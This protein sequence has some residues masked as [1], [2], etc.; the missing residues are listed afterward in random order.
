V[1]TV[2][3]IQQHFIE[4]LNHAIRRPGMFGPGEIGLDHT[5][6]DVV[7]VTETGDRQ[8]WRAALAAR[9]AW[10]SIGVEGRLMLLMPETE[11][12]AAASVYADYAH[13]HEWLALD[14]VLTSDEYGELRGELATWCAVDRVRS[15]VVARLGEPSV[16]IGGSG[17][18]AHGY[19]RPG[20]PIVW[21]HTGSDEVVLSG[22]CGGPFVE[23]LLFTPE[24]ARRRPAEDDEE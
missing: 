9:D 2:E 1:L 6:T 13:E 11:Q 8:T 10:S 22:R 15:D 17:D 18:Q 21:F 19:G 24:G 23:S 20:E 3:Q 16:R 14:R 7:Y 4:V 12:V 5:L